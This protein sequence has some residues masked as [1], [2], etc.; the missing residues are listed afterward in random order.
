MW[1]WV[2][3]D[4]SYDGLKPYG[5]G[6]DKPSNY[7][8]FNGYKVDNY[9]PYDYKYTYISEDRSN[10][11]NMSS[12]A[13][14]ISYDKNNKPF[15]MI[16]SSKV[17]EVSSNRPSGSP[18]ELL[19]VK[20][21]NASGYPPVAVTFYDYVWRKEWVEGVNPEW[22]F[23]IKR[24]LDGSAKITFLENGKPVYSGSKKI[25]ADCAYDDATP[26]GEGT[27]NAIY[28]LN[29]KA[30]KEPC[31]ELSDY[32]GNSTVKGR[33]AIQIH[34]GNKTTESEGCFVASNYA[35]LDYVRERIDSFWADFQIKSTPGENP[36][37]FY[38]FPN[39]IKVT[40][41]G[42]VKQPT[43]NMP[44][45]QAVDSP[46]KDRPYYVKMF[47]KDDGIAPGITKR[48]EITFSVAGSTAKVGEDY[49][50]GSNVLKVGSDKYKISVGAN[51]R[52]F[53][54]PVLLLA[55]KKGA[56]PEGKETI[57]L[58]IIDIELFNPKEIYS[59]SKYS[60]G[61]P[62]G[63]ELLLKGKDTYELSIKADKPVP[64][65]AASRSNIENKPSYDFQDPD[66]R[67]NFASKNEKK[68]HVDGHGSEKMQGR[69]G[70]DIYIIADVKDR[71][72][73]AKGGGAD[74]VLAS[75]S[76][77]LEKGQEVETLATTKAT[78]T[79][80]INLIGNEFANTVRGNAGANVL[81]G[82]DGND[83]LIGLGGRDTFAF[84]T[85]LGSFNVDHLSDFSAIDDTIQLSKGI[86][87]AL[88]AGT[89][90]AS[91]FKDL[92]VAGAKIDANDRILYNKTTGAL[93]YD[94]DGNGS[95]AAVQFT[96]I[97][98]KV[99]LTHTDFFVV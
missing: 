43:F 91:A 33:T 11:W 40:V 51:L 15:G 3:Y 42:Y 28:R 71:T 26:I 66:D 68:Y 50:F 4:I 90:V 61:F 92:S 52:N 39:P 62:K 97:D 94:A 48:A 79:S 22:E 8:T 59:D 47:V 93:Y 69:M 64:A 1:M 41:S 75:I 36:V 34:V 78:A 20:E 83:T 2:K 7:V 70:D 96:V 14:G 60:K 29:G 23:K 19:T 81:N 88:S 95:K 17:V 76:Y 74:T 85:A 16:F 32:S 24:A 67:S 44:T 9:I 49:N 53:D 46:L 82:L 35:F 13:S 73:E 10:L 45:S 77:S 54:I 57:K 65:K 6:L 98:T 99:A 63:Y 87:T 89:L 31:I 80:A 37:K 25:E 84:S 38:D 27:Y 30:N 56:R 58:T 18:A 12:V 86:F 21:Q 72:I 5:P 55:D